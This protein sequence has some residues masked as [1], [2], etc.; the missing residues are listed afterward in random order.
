[1]NELYEIVTRLKGYG[2]DSF[3]IVKAE[4]TAT[5]WRIELK[6]PVISEVAD[7]ESN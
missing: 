6:S 7:N 5:G 2:S 4:K 1:M 3:E